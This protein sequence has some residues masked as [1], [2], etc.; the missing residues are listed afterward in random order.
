MAD[1]TLDG[2]RACVASLKT[3]VGPA[4][5]AS[6]DKLAREQAALIAKYLSFLI[7][8]LDHAADRSRA[9]LSHHV[10]MGDA[11]AALLAAAGLADDGLDAAL[12]QGRDALAQ[13]GAA[14]AV[15][16][17]ATAQVQAALGRIVRGL[18]EQAHPLRAPV[19]RAVLHGS[20]GIVALQR[21]WFAP[22]GWEAAGAAPDLETLLPDAGP[23]PMP[24]PAT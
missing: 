11:V 13:G 7:D 5:E 19:E 14:K 3:V 12:G 18:G 21:A 1:R 6:G 8:R 24:S 22:Q 4:V 23:L 10:A 2:L 9:E 20:R 16:E 15:L 17:T